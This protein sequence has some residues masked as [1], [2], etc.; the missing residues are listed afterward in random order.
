[1]RLR[2][3]GL[4]LSV[5]ENSRIMLR[6]ENEQEKGNWLEVRVCTFQ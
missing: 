6:I 2:L 4:E 1:M 3:P 5:G